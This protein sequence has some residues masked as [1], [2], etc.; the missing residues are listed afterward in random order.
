MNEA[1]AGADRYAAPAGTWLHL[2]RCKG[3]IYPALARSLRIREIVE[4]LTNRPLGILLDQRFGIVEC[5]LLGQQAH[6][7]GVEETPPH[8]N[9]D[10]AIVIGS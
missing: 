9:D 6:I 8:D 3:G 4:E 2:V 10:A 1:L 7:A 5:P